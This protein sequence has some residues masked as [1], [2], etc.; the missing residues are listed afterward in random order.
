MLE[1]F[2]FGGKKGVRVF[3]VWIFY[4]EINLEYI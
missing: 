4:K 2:E 3:R 1:E